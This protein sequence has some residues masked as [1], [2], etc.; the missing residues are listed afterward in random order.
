MT[1]KKKI[2]V[3]E[4]E[5]AIRSAICQSLLKLGYS[6]LE[7]PDGKSGLDQALAEHPDLII[8]DIIMPKLHGIDLYKIIRDDKWGKN[9]KI[10]I[11][12]NVASDLTVQKAAE[13][14]LTKL[15]V[16]ND[17]K[18]KDFLPEVTKYLEE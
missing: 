16:K 10:I 8:T 13:H 2:L 4:D 1:D 18:L 11:L 5:E 15:T 9:A 12:T 6:V 7:A 3:V 14:P 17:I